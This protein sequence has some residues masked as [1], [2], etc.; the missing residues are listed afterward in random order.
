MPRPA[1]TSTREG[2]NKW[3]A[4]SR[5]GSKENSIRQV[6]RRS[7]PHPADSTEFFLRKNL[8]LGVFVSWGGCHVRNQYP[9]EFPRQ[10]CKIMRMPFS[11]PWSRKPRRTH[12]RR[13]RRAK[14]VV[15]GIA[16][17]WLSASVVGCSPPTPVPA[18]P[19]SGGFA[20]VGSHT[21]GAAA[22]STREGFTS[23]QTAHSVK[24][25]VVAQP[26]L[27]DPWQAALETQ[28]E[29]DQSVDVWLRATSGVTSREHVQQ[30]LILRRIHGTGGFLRQADPYVQEHADS[31]PDAA[32]RSLTDLRQRWDQF[33]HVLA[34]LNVA[35]A[36]AQQEPRGNP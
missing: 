28:S 27:L 4:S 29:L 34:Q 9:D 12:C 26:Q 6:E 35:Q 17:G 5:L 2:E 33:E 7:Q 32:R 23:R 1:E 14:A 3:G 21:T 30:L 8:L 31:F 13:L 22:P 16:L 15:A 24:K 10:E 20:R 11:F 25:P 36:M 18:T 19:L